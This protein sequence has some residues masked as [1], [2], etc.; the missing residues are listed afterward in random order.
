MALAKV[1]T[2]DGYT[3]PNAIP[4]GGDIVAK[5]GTYNASAS[6]KFGSACGE[7]VNGGFVQ[8]S[9]AN[10]VHGG[11]IWVNVVTAITGS[12]R[13]VTFT[14][15]SSTFMGMIRFH[16]SGIWDIC[17]N[18]TTRQAQSI[19]SWAV[20][21]WYRVAYLFT[22]SGLN[23]VI[24]CRIYSGNGNGTPLWDSGNV[25]VTSATANP[26]T[27][28]RIGAQGVTAGTV[29]NDQ[30]RLYTTAEWTGTDRAPSEG[31]LATVIDLAA[32]V[33]KKSASQGLLALTL[34][35]DADGEKT[36]AAS[37][38]IAVAAPISAEGA[39]S[40]ASAGS[41]STQLGLASEILKSAPAAGSAVLELSMQAVASGSR[42]AAGAL[43]V[44]AGLSAV[45]SKRGTGAG[46][47][48]LALGLA[49][50]VGEVPP[51]QRAVS[52][53]VAFGV[54]VAS[55]NY[56][57]SPVTGVVELAVS[58]TGDAAKQGSGIGSLELL[59][60]MSGTVA[61]QGGDEPFVVVRHGVSV[62]ATL[63]GVVR[64]GTLVPVVSSEVH[65]AQG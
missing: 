11:S 37:A 35:P 52:G 49:G 22:G 41:V 28:I 36:A 65:R 59:L 61:S 31:T 27:R 42:A 44:A 38:P 19:A 63:G 12:A 58:A 13:V 57:V 9:N 15:A 48:G 18:T 21:A 50:Y 33:A 7:S 62:P 51:D 6:S 32:F 20:G 26:C 29:R 60:A 24:A 30:F 45:A 56:R 2:F 3:P 25:A 64:N 43:G 46:T 10:D 53:L 4:T 5:T 34:P 23:R 8:I 14:D 40:V 55:S 17:D 54:S 39:K 47:T 1:L 16:T